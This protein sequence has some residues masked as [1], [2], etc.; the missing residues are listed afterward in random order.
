MQ[1]H[2]FVFDAV[3]RQMF[4]RNCGVAMAANMSVI[5]KTDEAHFGASGMGVTRQNSAK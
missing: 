4:C 2:Y 3:R 5:C 1:T